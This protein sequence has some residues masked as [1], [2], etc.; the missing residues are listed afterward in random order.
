MPGLRGAGPQNADVWKGATPTISHFSRDR[1][2]CFRIAVVLGE[3][4]SARAQ[5]TRCRPADK[6]VP[7][8]TRGAPRGSP[9][10]RGWVSAIPYVPPSPASG[11]VQDIGAAVR[12]LV[13]T[14]DQLVSDHIDFW[15]PVSL[16][17]LIAKT[18]SLGCQL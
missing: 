17:R 1:R 9:G 5:P 12:P 14:S 10:E 18:A 4:R 6:S 16:F 11:C 13:N 3:E 7:R 8:G 2:R 15:G